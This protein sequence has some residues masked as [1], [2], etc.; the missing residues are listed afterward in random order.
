MRKKKKSKSEMVRGY[1]VPL[2]IFS[3]FLENW[4]KTKRKT[5]QGSEIGNRM[6]GERHASSVN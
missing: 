6:T 4:D 2:S 1:G 5:A 3:M